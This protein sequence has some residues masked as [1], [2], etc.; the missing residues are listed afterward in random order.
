VF[1]LRACLILFT[2]LIISPPVFAD[3]VP[4]TFSERS[5]IDSLER[6][7]VLRDIE[8][9]HTLGGGICALGDISG[10]GCSDILV[11]R[12][13]ETLADTSLS[14]L[15]YG[16]NPPSDTFVA[17]FSAFLPNMGE[18]GDLNGD[19][20]LD[21]SGYL[22]N[23]IR[24]AVHW[25]G[26]SI[27]DIP[28]W[29]VQD[30]SSSVT[31]LGDLNV[32]GRKDLV[33]S[34]RRNGGDV[35]LYSFDS[36]FDTVSD[37]TFKDT[38]ENFGFS[39]AIGEFNGDIY[40]DLAIVSALRRDTAVVNLYWGGPGFDTIPDLKIENTAGRFG[41]LILAI[42]DFNADGYDDL[43]I[44]GASNDSYGIYFGGPGI[45]GVMDARVNDGFWPP[46]SVDAAG[47]LN[48]DGIEDL[49]VGYS[50]SPDVFVNRVYV[51]LGG[52]VTGYQLEPDVILDGAEIPGGQAPFG[53]VLKGIGDFNGDGIDDFAVGSNTASSGTG[54]WGEV[55]VF[56]G[57]D[58]V[59]TDVPYDYE[60]TLPYGYELSQNY[61]NPFNPS[62]TIQFALPMA[63]ETELVIYNILGER[64][65]TLIDRNLAAGSYTLEWDGTNAQGEPVASGV[66]VYRL[67]SGDYTTSR[68]M[69]LTR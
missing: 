43:F 44:S 50:L 11:T 38:L 7:V 55:Y 51:F 54:W 58:G 17:Q 10:D 62:T 30:H 59:T 47:D 64:V 40:D 42:P 26:P 65:T 24:F 12:R 56:A 29:V 23:P 53:K 52:D 14:F 63:G 20:F 32:D 5:G 6:I 3:W 48:N 9:E 37:L 19:G 36:P 25:G 46:T 60:P 41:E 8:M 35:D 13:E 34:I 4:G 45:D 31:R 21:L 1:V 61:P 2:L 69:V 67:Q 22:V 33:V 66:Y 27:D 39:L 57:W 68:K 16:G 49:V 28:D 15:F 18:I